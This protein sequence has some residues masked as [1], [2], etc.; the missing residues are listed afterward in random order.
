M[1]NSAQA[2]RPRSTWKGRLNDLGA[3]SI[4]MA[5]ADLINARLYIP[6]E[7]RTTSSQFKSFRQEVFN[8]IYRA[9]LDVSGGSLKSATVSVWDHPDEDDS[10]T[11]DLSMTFDESWTD[12]R[13]IGNQI[14]DRIAEFAKTWTAD[15]I[16]YFRMHIYFNLMSVSP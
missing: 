5:R 1:A 4:S 9:A 16:E 6:I 15:E 13:Q 2:I 11:F 3:R 7:V 10:L 14:H 8:D 12:I